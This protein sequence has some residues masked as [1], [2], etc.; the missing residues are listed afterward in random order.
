MN[1]IHVQTTAPMEILKLMHG[2]EAL[3]RVPGI[4]LVQ[5][6]NSCK[7][8]DLIKYHLNRYIKYHDGFKTDEFPRLIGLAISYSNLEIEDSMRSEANRLGI[9]L[10]QSEIDEHLTIEYLI[11]QG[12]TT[13][14]K[15]HNDFVPEKMEEILQFAIVRN[16][17]RVARFIVEDCNNCWVPIDLTNILRNTHHRYEEEIIS[18]VDSDLGQLMNLYDYAITLDKRRFFIKLYKRYPQWYQVKRLLV[19]KRVCDKFNIMNTIFGQSMF[20]L[21]FMVL[22][23]LVIIIDFLMTIYTI[24]VSPILAI[25]LLVLLI[26]LLIIMGTLLRDTEKNAFEDMHNKMEKSK[27]SVPNSV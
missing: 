10:S 27:L 5:I 4:V 21:P 17:M 23:T 19:G 18:L 22:I 7:I 25:S 14:L 2:S 1:V 24:H 13:L 9:T 8:D 16:R 3:E 11:Y 20:Y 15:Q 6:V 12:N 26:I